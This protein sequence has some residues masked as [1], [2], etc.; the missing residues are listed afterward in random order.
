MY[1]WHL[2]GSV[3]DNKEFAAARKLLEEDQDFVF[4]DEVFNTQSG[5]CP[6]FIVSNQATMMEQL[7]Y[8]ASKEGELNEDALTVPL[9][10]ID[11]AIENIFQ[12]ADEGEQYQGRIR[13]LAMP[14]GYARSLVAVHVNPGRHFDFYVM[15]NGRGLV[16]AQG[17]PIDYTGEF[18]PG[19]KAS[20]GVHGNQG[21]GLYNC[22]SLDESCL[23]SKGK[24]WK[25]VREDEGK[26]IL[27]L[28]DVTDQF[29][30]QKQLAQ[31]KGT[32]VA[33]R[34]HYPTK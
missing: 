20:H 1:L 28:E 18:Q 22:L 16:D 14:E 13:G 3:N 9:Y 30:D 32:I 15:D 11:S 27:F 6:E 24:L 2:L 5:D 12:H 34:I 23:A 21:E 31:T 26:E 8:F 25:K 19:R 29:P 33:A 7:L 17:Q 4:F 10:R